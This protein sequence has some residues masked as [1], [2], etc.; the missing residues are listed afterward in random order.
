MKWET[1]FKNRGPKDPY[2]SNPINRLI[3]EKGLCQDV[4]RALFD[5]APDTGLVTRRVDRGVHKKGSV[6][7][8]GG[9]RDYI[10]VQIGSLG[11]FKLHRIIWLWWYGYT[12]ESGIDHINGA[13]S[14]NR[15]TNLREISQSC[16]MFNSGNFTTNTTGVRGVTFSSNPRHKTFCV[17]I[18]YLGTSRFL[19]WSDNL[20]EA[21]L[22]RHTAEQCL[23]LFACR[24]NSSAYQYLKQ[25]GVLK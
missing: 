16:N 18:H 4:V 12:P 19:G 3:D 21:A 9:D 22:L 10:C 2:K 20:T 6:L 24:E 14:D 23:G 15:L 7:S 5:Y 1:K 8:S 17:R 11:N 13:K 25:Q